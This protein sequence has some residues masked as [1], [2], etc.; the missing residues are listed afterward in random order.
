[1]IRFTAAMVIVAAIGQC[2]AMYSGWFSSPATSSLLINVFIFALTVV[3]YRIVSRISDR[4][5][6]TQVYLA[7]IV[8]K[9]IAACGFAAVIIV[10]DRNHFKS[11]VVFLLVLYVTFTI[12]EVAFLM[13]AAKG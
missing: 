10:L 12:V 6:F 2:V 4:Q 13:R 1:M 8:I 9:I 11:N 7:T 3:V 5:R